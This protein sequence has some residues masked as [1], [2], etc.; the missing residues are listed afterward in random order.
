MFAARRERLL[1]QLRR[2]GLDAALISHPINVSYL[3]GFTGDATCLLV[4]SART[5]AVSD[6]RFTDQ[7]AEEC[8]GLEAVIR[9]PVQPL[10]EAVAATIEKLGALEVS[11][12]NSH[13]TVAEFTSLSA[14]TKSVAWKPSS[15]RVERQ[16]MVKD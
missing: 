8:P 4:S 13:L 5:V 9:P 7:L 1:E 14:L 10:I 16:R 11:F 2:E 12:E 6:G 15:D 3:T